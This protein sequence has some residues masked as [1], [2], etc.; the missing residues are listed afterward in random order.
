MTKDRTK[1]SQN[2]RNNLIMR[3]NAIIARYYYYSELRRIRLDDS[4]SLVA[5]DFYLSEISV[6]RIVRAG[7]DAL[8]EIIMKRVSVAELRKLYVQFRFR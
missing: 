1:T 6:E 5:R 7:N 4:I 8:N 3:N 2:R